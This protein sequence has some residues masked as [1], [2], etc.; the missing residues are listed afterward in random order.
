MIMFKSF[1]LFITQRALEQTKT[2]ECHEK[3]RLTIEMM[4]KLS[5]F[6]QFSKQSI[7]PFIFQCH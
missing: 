1:D 6:L 3:K 4:C 2:Y 5:G 7:L